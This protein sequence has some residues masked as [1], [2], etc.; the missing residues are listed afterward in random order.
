MFK[1]IMSLQS[2][3]PVLGYTGYHTKSILHNK[4]LNFGNDAKV[5]LFLIVKKHLEKKLHIF[6]FI[7]RNA[8]SK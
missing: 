2:C 3:K 7:I 8:L 6:I 5:I 4:D 1:K